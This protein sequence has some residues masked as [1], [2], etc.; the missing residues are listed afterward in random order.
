MRE[1]V[2][3]RFTDRTFGAQVELIRDGLAGAQIG[4]VVVL[5]HNGVGGV[6]QPG[7]K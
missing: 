7:G 5:D 4:A 1:K 2:E 6:I 3:I